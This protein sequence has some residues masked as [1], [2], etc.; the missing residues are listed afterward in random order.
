MYLRISAHESIREP[1]MEK[2]NY[3]ATMNTFST[4]CLKFY[5]RLLT[6]I[7]DRFVFDDALFDLISVLE[8]RNAQALNVLSLYPILQRFSCLREYVNP[9]ILDN[10]WRQHSLLDHRLLELNP[11]LPASEYW[12]K[13][14]NIKNTAGSAKFK[15][16]KI[17]FGLLLILHFSDA[18]VERI[19]S[20]LNNIETDLRNK[21]N[22]DTVASILMP[23]DGIKK[24]G[25]A[26]NFQP[27]DKMLQSAICY[28]KK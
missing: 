8:P 22:T 12:T 15:Y 26:L 2:T 16:L 25:G 24:L 11:D 4:S 7:K 6:E 10:E 5:I 3:Q 13:V 17:V 9:Q 21:L 14:F 1:N 23:K 28:K 20:N 19:N 27:S 18:S